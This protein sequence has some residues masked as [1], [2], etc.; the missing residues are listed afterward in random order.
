MFTNK[1][2]I[3]LEVLKMISEGVVTSKDVKMVKR[4]NLDNQYQLNGSYNDNIEDLKTCCGELLSKLDAIEEYLG[5][6]FG[7]GGVEVTMPSY[8]KVKKTRKN[9]SKK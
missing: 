6:E 2:K 1:N 3:R 8:K 7:G 9:G 4:D 5:I